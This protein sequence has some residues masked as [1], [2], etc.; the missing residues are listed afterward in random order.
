MTD[1]SIFL[2]GVVVFMSCFYGAFM[3][4]R[5]RE[6]PEDDLAARRREEEIPA[7]G[8]ATRHP[9][10]SPSPNRAG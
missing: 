8:E 6:E 2:L 10:S 7:E 9:V 1:Q 4:L 3:F 5:P